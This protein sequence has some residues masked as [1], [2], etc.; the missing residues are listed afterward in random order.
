MQQYRET[1]EA[2][3][4]IRVQS[5]DDRTGVLSIWH[6]TTQGEK[7]ET[8]NQ[9]LTLAVDDDGQRVPSW[10]KQADRI[11]QLPPVNS[12][13]EARLSLLTDSLEPMIHRE[14]VHRGFLGENRGYNARLVAWVEIV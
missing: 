9:M 1:P 2:E 11:F 7:G 3:I 8:R 10:E 4:G 5:G 12:N 14:L 13:G 6:V